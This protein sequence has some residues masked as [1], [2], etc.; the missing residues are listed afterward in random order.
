MNSSHGIRLFLDT[1]GW[2]YYKL[3]Q[4]DLALKY[5]SQS[6]EVSPDN[7]VVNDHLG[8]VYQAKNEI[9]KAIQYWKRA[10]E[11]APDNNNIKLKIEQYS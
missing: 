6:L 10:L 1:L 11:L 4:F 2:I 5:I 3:A 8:D 9:D 7:S